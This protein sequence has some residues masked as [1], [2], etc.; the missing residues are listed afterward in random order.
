MIRNGLT[1]VKDTWRGATEWWGERDDQRVTY[2]FPTRALLLAAIDGGYAE[3]LPGHELRTSHT[4]LG[5]RPI[6]GFNTPSRGTRG[7]CSCGEWDDRVNEAPSAG[8][9]RWLF[10]KWLDE[11]LSIIATGGAP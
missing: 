7:S 4:L 11:H 2:E 5:T 1:I 3:L 10:E 9:E 6:R 8:G